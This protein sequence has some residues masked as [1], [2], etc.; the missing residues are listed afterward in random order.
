MGFPGPKLTF[1]KPHHFGVTST[2]R[3][4]FGRYNLQ[5]GSCKVVPGSSVRDPNFWPNYNIS[6]T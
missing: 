6:P 1:F 2:G 4:F 5:M 3:D